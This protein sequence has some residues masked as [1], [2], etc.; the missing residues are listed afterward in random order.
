MPHTPT[1]AVVNASEQAISD[2]EMADTTGFISEESEDDMF[3]E[4]EDDEPSVGEISDN[5]RSYVP[6]LTIMKKKTSTGKKALKISW[7]V[8]ELDYD[9]DYFE[10]FRA[11]AK[12]QFTE[13]PYYVTKTP[14]T[15]AYTNKKVKAG[16][17]YYYKVRGVKVLGDTKIY[18]AFSQIKSKK[19]K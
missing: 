13:K 10:V 3:S 7:Q 9:V 16:Q 12:D 14:T 17:T 11:T 4:E 1:P 19:V 6:K 8:D 2:S 5:L 18:T 15:I